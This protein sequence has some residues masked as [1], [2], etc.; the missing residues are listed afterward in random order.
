[1]RWLSGLRVQFP[2]SRPSVNCWSSDSWILDSEFWLLKGRSPDLSP[3]VV[4]GRSPDLSPI[5]VMSS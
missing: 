1:M 2:G 3:I 4:K 5:V